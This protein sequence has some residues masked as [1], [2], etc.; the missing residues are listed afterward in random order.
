[1]RRCF[2][3]Y[4]V[5]TQNFYNYLGKIKKTEKIDIDIDLTRDVFFLSAHDRCFCDAESAWVCHHFK[6]RKAE[7]RVERK[8][9]GLISKN[10]STEHRWPSGAKNGLSFLI[11]NFKSDKKSS[12]QNHISIP[13]ETG[14]A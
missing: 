11:F 8:Q 4:C 12:F 1:L 14:S 6:N 2:E 13:L 5:V 7:C 10:V 3:L 9:N